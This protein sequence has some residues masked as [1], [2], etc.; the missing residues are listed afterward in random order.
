MGQD[1]RDASRAGRLFVDAAAL[2][3]RAMNLEKHELVMRA[4]ARFRAE[5]EEERLQVHLVFLLYW[6]KST[7]SDAGGGGTPAVTN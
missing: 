1:A 4:E 3:K 6:Y 2:F 7:N 5:E